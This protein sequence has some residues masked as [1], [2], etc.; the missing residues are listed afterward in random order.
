MAL[1]HIRPNEAL[2]RELLDVARDSD[3]LLE[4]LRAPNA[5]PESFPTT[6][7]VEICRSLSDLPEGT[8]EGCR[9][10]LEY[11]RVRLPA[12][13]RE[14]IIG[15]D[16]VPAP[17]NEDE[18]PPL[19]RG[20][21]LDRLF[22]DLIASATTALDEYRLQASEHF[23]DTVGPELTVDAHGDA[24]VRSAID[25]S[26]AVEEQ[27]HTAAET[28]RET[29]VSE[30]G[31][32]DQLR[33]TV[34]DAENVN[35]LARAELRMKTV[36]VRWFL[37]T[38][39]SLKDYP[40]LIRR[41]GDAIVVGVDVLQPLNQRWSDFWSNFA[42]FTLSEARECGFALQQV[43]EN[44][45]R[46][47]TPPKAH[48]ADA[49]A[50]RYPEM[51]S[52]EPGSFNMGSHEHQTEKPPHQVTIGYRFSVGK[53]PVTFAEY[54][55]FCEA[56]GRQKPDD[57]W[58]GRDRR[59]VI[60]VSWEDAGAYVEWLS[61]TTEKPYR[62]LSES[63]WEYCCRSGTETNFSYGDEIGERDA[64]LA[65]RIGRTTAVGSYPGNNWGLHDMHGNVW[66]WVEDVWHDNYVGAPANGG[67]WMEGGDPS[68][69]LLRG[70]SWLVR[71]L[72]SR[73]AVRGR[74]H[75]GVLNYAIGFRVAR[76][77]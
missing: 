25:K 26:R 50:P 40:R 52:I 70:G 6:Q 49:D 61:A 55:A 72:G 74:S 24:G 28:I 30:S 68:G 39:E 4:F 12:I 22:R 53:Y 38:V 21:G 27:L 36:V 71:P 62:L 46:R 37:A 54:D 13:R 7:V 3:L 63:E 17:E 58:W 18:A 16:Q 76:T 51:V 67:A 77:L 11:A 33:R 64:N 19:V 20:M 35:R 10:P 9:A 8:A 48:E 60:N 44:L 59:P 41:C 5:V 32:A 2:A 43:G 66:E 1:R 69:R 47:R 73:S 14:H 57:Q 34:K 45:E 31:R 42:N 75:F 65:E 56:T 29:T 15:E 23:D